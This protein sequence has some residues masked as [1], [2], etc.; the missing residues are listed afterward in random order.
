MIYLGKGKIESS[1]KMADGLLFSLEAI[2]HFEAVNINE[3]PLLPG[4]KTSEQH[5]AAGTC[6]K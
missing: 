4:E 2:W 5:P 1:N 6:L 3:L